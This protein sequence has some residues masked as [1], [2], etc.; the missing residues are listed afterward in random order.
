MGVCSQ[1]TIPN[2]LKMTFSHNFM[3]HLVLF[4][5]FASKL[6][7]IRHPGNRMV[8]LRELTKVFETAVDSNVKV[9]SKISYRAIPMLAA[10]TQSSNLTIVQNVNGNENILKLNGEMIQI[11]N[12]SLLR[13]KLQKIYD[14]G[15]T[16]LKVP[17]N[18]S[19]AIILVSN[20]NQ[21][22]HPWW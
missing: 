22:K 11:D 12:L 15:C 17:E 18:L 7:E 19:F 10:G 14:R 9:D 13:T 3:R 20:R 16:G 5:N 1:A 6:L 8:L 4:S 2:S 21:R